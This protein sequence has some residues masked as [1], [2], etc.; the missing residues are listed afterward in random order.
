MQHQSTSKAQR[1]ARVLRGGMTDSERKLWSALRSEQLGVKFRRQHPLGNYIADFACLDPRLIVELDGSQHT[2]QEAYDARR[3]AF[4]RVQGFAVMR[5][6]SNEPLRNLAGVA[7]AIL[8]QLQALAGHA[9]I[10]AFPQRGKEKLPALLEREAEELPAF[11]QK[12]EQKTP[13]SIP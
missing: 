2:D 12:G 9:P 13:R 4:F 11:L 5:F 8:E 1:N 3:D 7:T 10:P 6:P